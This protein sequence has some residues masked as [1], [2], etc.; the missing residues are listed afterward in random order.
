MGLFDGLFK[1]KGNAM[2]AYM[3]GKCVKIQEVPDPT[4]GDEILGKGIA[5]I[6]TDGK[7]YAPAD[8]EI[9]MVFDTKHAVSLITGDGAELLIHIG[10]ETVS[11]N[12]EPFK[13]HVAAGDKVKKGDLLIEADLDMIQEK[14]CPIITPLVVCNSDDFSSIEG[15]TDKQVKVGDDVLVLNK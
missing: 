9:A 5:I 13:A 8:G 1:K 4:F 14:G 10:L 12:G 15:L 7:V 3:E 11:L 2:G 6:P